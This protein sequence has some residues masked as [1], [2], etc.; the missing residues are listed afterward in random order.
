MNNIE[1][2]IKELSQDLLEFKK[3]MWALM[4]FIDSAASDAQMNQIVSSPSYKEHLRICAEKQNQI[5]ALKE[6]LQGASG[7]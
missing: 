3:E 7:V 4:D 2:Q 6:Q 5:D 1:E